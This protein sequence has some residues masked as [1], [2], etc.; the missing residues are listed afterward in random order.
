MQDY[1]YEPQLPQLALIDDGLRFDGFLRANGEVG[2]RNELWILP[3]VGCVNEVAESL[4]RRF[5][6][7]IPEGVDGVYAFTHPYG[8]SQLGDDH[9]NTQKILAGLARHPNAAGVLLIGLGCENNTME[10][11]RRQIGDDDPGRYRDPERYRY[12]IAQDETDEFSTGFRRLEELAAL[13]GRARR[14]SVPI[15]RL[16]IGMKC[17]GSDG[18]SG[19][20]ANPLI[21]AVCDKLV[22]RGA[23]AALT[24]VPEMF[25]AESLFVNRCRDRE[26]FD[27]CVAMVNGFKEYFLRHG[28]PVYE[29]PSPGNNEGGITTL[30][31]KS[32]GCLQKGGTTPV[33]D[34]LPY[35]GRLAQPGLN[36]VAGPGN[37]LVSTTA[38]AAAGC[39]MV[40]FST[41]RGTPFGGPVPTPKIA[42]NTPLAQRKSGWIDFDAGRLVAG[43]SMPKLADELLALIVDI[44]SGRQLTRNE[45]NGCRQIAIFKEGVTL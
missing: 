33:M 18:L 40:L 32:L 31:E 24:E 39:Q 44:A 28:Q 41:G 1:R 34:V 2:I 15:A 38:L 9:L 30:E 26:T 35:G 42:S 11:L 43:A 16:R 5:G 29:N 23:T 22:A 12:L 25:G 13:A 3:T 10:S 36:L 8:C 45:I 7:A 21:G 4:A 17:G 14:Q 6:E 20:T 19:I 37:D 27:K